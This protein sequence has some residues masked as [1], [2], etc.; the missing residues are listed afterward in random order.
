MDEVK[1]AIIPIISADYRFLPYSKILP[2]A[3]WLLADKPIL[4]YI[5]KEARD[6]G[7]EEIV[8]VVDSKKIDVAKYFKKTD[9]TKLVLKNKKKESEDLKELAEL[10]KD[11]TFSVVYQNR[12]TGIDNALIQASQ[13]ISKK[14]VAVFLPHQ[15]IVSGAPC[16]SQ[17][18]NIF[19]T[20]QR[21][22]L[23]LKRVSKELISSND[24]I[25]FDKIAKRV[26]KIRKITKNPLPEKADS[27][28]AI[29]GRYILTPEVFEYLKKA[30]V[31]KKEGVLIS[32]LNKMLLDGKNI[33]GYEFEGKLFELNGKEDWLKAHA[34]FSLRDPK[35]NSGLKNFLKE[36][37]LI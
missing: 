2:K 24:I 10:S 8:F 18:I 7:I 6:S 17:L 15:I 9:R 31:D 37:G 16:I 20:A 4:Q 26:L 29:M 34:Y 19:K 13:K 21:P 27:D 11:L 12:K 36:E 25:E 5:V 32:S 35:Y 14:P 1:K 30:K 22:V 33:Y 28:L 23:G 3:F